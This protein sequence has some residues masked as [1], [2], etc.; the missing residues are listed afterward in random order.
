MY[1]FEK[2]SYDENHL[3]KAPLIKKI[4]VGIVASMVTTPSQLLLWF[5]PFCVLEE[6]ISSPTLQENVDRKTR[7]DL[8]NFTTAIFTGRM[9]EAYRFIESM[10]DILTLKKM[11]YYCMEHELLDAA[12]SCFAQMGRAYAVSA[13]D[14]MNYG[15]VGVPVTPF[16]FLS[17]DCQIDLNYM[18]K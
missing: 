18:V 16:C 2:L 7:Q 10:N 4:P 14:S 9:M 6:F 13:I 3:P 11:A 1:I 12:M 8:L 17:S 5:A 15:D